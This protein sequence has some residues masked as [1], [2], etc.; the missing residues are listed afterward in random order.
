M[1]NQQTE[2]RIK[3]TLLQYLDAG[4]KVTL[5]WDCGSDEAFV[6]TSIDGKEL[7]SFVDGEYQQ[8]EF[9]ALLEHFIITEL[10]LPSA[11]EFSLEGKG[12]IR[13]ENNQLVIVYEAVNLSYEDYQYFEDED[14]STENKNT[15][16][17][18]QKK[19]DD[20]EDKDTD[21]EEEY[22][23]QYVNASPE[24]Y[25]EYSGKKVLFTL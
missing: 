19:E 3:E 25:A 16:Q 1:N 18:D 24:E 15:I 22:N 11:G 17:E 4:K 7:S 14:D 23:S 8:Y 9:P 10:A 2:Q 13:K 6:Q 20:N 21:Y 5:T 12:E